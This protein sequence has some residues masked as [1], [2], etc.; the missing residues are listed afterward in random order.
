M[1]NNFNST[2][3]SLDSLQTQRATIKGNISIILNMYQDG[4]TSTNPIALEFRLEILSSYIKQIMAY[5]TKI[6]KINPDDTKRS[7]IEEVCISAKSLLLSKLSDGK[8]SG[9][10]DF[11]LSVPQVTPEHRLQV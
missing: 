6:E 11:P 2:E 9:V 5:Q 8:Q 10:N 3:Q 4:S 1:N 7:E